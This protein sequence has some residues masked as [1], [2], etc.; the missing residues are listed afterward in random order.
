MPAQSVKT[1]R[2]ESDLDLGKSTSAL[3]R[4]AFLTN[5]IPP[6]R[7]GT[8]E[9]LGL[10]CQQLQILVST[11]MEE[12]RQTWSSAWP[13]LDVVV[14][15][16]LTFKRPLKHPHRRDESNYVHLPLDTV[17][18]LHSFQADVI[19]SVEMGVR[20][21]LALLYRKLSRRCILLIW[22]DVAESTELGRGWTRSIV[23]R[24]LCGNTD[25]FIVNG[26]SGARYLRTIGV[27]QSRVFVIPYATDID[28]FYRPNLRQVNSQH[29]TF[30]YV[31]QLIE[32][33]G[34]VPFI[35][36]LARWAEINSSSQITLLIAGDG[37]LRD[38][39]ANAAVPLNL[40]LYMLGNVAYEE[41]PAV[42]AQADV[43]AFP[44][45]A[46]TWGLVVNEAM[47]AGLPVLGSTQA[48]A[49]EEM[50]SE[51]VTGWVFRPDDAEEM[52][53]AI[54]RCLATGPENLT[55][56]QHKA[57]QTALRLTPEYVARSIQ[58]AVIACLDECSGPQAR[59][60]HGSA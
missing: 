43:F 10:R 27:S 8:L 60:A 48:Q 26:A 52:Y 12:N 21:L 45:Y 57:Q 4:V 42:Y 25:A 17:H 19:I 39:I 38:R 14:Q 23:R 44:S 59:T 37:P 1:A 3:P 32:R 11:P 9:H 53:S 50:V 2:V 13:G 24:L 55:E 54:E 6:Y 33:K 46:E 56:M 18:A 22:A 7:V 5:F 15:K 47:A 35:T 36:M 41:L 16:T 31:G 49:V 40:K 30:V 29:R 28:R 51:G 20:S 58:H 34:L